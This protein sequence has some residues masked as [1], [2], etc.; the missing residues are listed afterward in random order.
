MPNIAAF[1]K[2]AAEYEAWFDRNRIV[3]QSELQ[4][5]EELLPEKGEGCEVGMGTGRFASALGIRHGID[6]SPRMREIARKRGIAAVGGVAEQLPYH[7][8]IFDFILMITTICFL[9]DIDMSF[10]ESHRVLKPEGQFIIGFIDKNSPVGKMYMQRK[11]ENKFYHA[12]SFYS[13]GDVIA[14][15]IKSCFK[16]LQ[17]K[18]TIFHS[19]D[20]IAQI[21]PVKDGYGEGSFV[22]VKAMKGGSAELYPDLSDESSMEGGGR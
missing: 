8:H 2:Y 3:F 12:A 17:F 18:Q 7:D 1:E 20:K 11:K 15:L 9:D 5:V 6:P 21:D 19:M 14:H 22:V 13:T 10:K 4:A 16:I